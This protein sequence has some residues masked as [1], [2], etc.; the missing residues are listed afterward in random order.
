VEKV[1]PKMLASSDQAEP[2]LSD[3]S[4]SLESRLTI[5]LEK[6]ER[7]AHIIHPEPMGAAGPAMEGRH[8]DG[9]LNSM[10]RVHDTAT[11]IERVLQRLSDTVGDL[12][13]VSV[14]DLAGMSEEG[15]KQRHPNTYP[16]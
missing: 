15:P 16:R 8:A 4:S 3:L 9:L 5:I 6:L 14:H 1:T 12:I 2:R 7:V 11:G 13:S 10:Q